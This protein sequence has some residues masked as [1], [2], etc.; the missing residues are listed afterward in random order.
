S[1]EPEEPEEDLNRLTAEAGARLSFDY[2]DSDLSDYEEHT[3]DDLGEIRTTTD[4]TR[5]WR[6]QQR[7]SLAGQPPPLRPLPQPSLSPVASPRGAAATTTTTTTTATTTKERPS[8]TAERNA[9]QE[10]VDLFHHWKQESSNEQKAQEA[11]AFEEQARY[12]QEQTAGEGVEVMETSQGEWVPSYEAREAP[13][14]VER[15]LLKLAL[16]EEAREE[17]KQAGAV[18]FDGKWISS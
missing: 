14:D 13:I 2:R 15:D 9:K 8:L 5:W 10:M 7:A 11:L 6:D 4:L 12:E 18:L 16:E 1:E 17:R 3:I